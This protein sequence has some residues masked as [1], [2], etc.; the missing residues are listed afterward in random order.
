VIHELAMRGEVAVVGLGRSGRAVSI[1]LRRDGA[2]VY[3]SDGG[4]GA[5]VERTAAELRALGVDA[6]TGGHDLE[7][8]SRA[9]VVVASPGVPPDSAP[10]ACAF[11]RGVPV[12]SE[13][14][15]AL[16]Y[17]PRTRCIAV[18]GTNGKTTVTALVDHLLRA[19]GHD[20]VAAGNIGLA[21]SE[22]ALRES[23][24]AWVA[25]EVSSFQLH[26]TPSL[27][28]AVGV[29][30]N[31]APDHL[32][33]YRSLEEYYGDKM[34]LFANASDAS[35]WVTNGDDPEVERRTARVRGRRHRFSLR[36]DRADACLTRTGALVVHGA[37]LM[38]RAGLPLLGDHNVANALAA[39]LSVM[40]ADPASESGAGRGR[41]SDALRA[42]RAMPHRLEVVADIAGVQWINDSKATNVSSARVAIEGMTR[43]AVVLLGGRH[44]GE[45]YTGL[46]DVLA[47]HARLVIAY[48]EAAPR[49]AAD[50]AGGV[51][52]EQ[53]GSSFDEVIARARAAAKP[54][55][56]VLLTPACSS[57]DMF[58][59][60]EERGAA[61]RRAAGSAGGAGSAPPTARP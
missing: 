12:V 40:A 5:P 60:Y 43:P 17:L 19:L 26:D 52:V 24:P 51:P 10:L 47:R 53:F 55:D 2:S 49:I 29:L 27:A 13:V 39:V 1:L 59:N 38:P 33:R 9:S 54:G 15:V 31:L 56:A 18:T 44:K 28:P 25:L 7:R 48:G 21:L 11:A 4:T 30:T 20:S 32:D 61:F 42:F 41:M 22:V 34:R 45:P 37:T 8:V 35:V 23:P 58:T 36:D 6:Q 14:E 16:D 57:F 46:A 3:A 50:L